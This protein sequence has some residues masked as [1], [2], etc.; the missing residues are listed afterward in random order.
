MP[1]FGSGKVVRGLGGSAGFGEMEMQRGDDL[2]LRLDLSS[3]FPDGFNY[4]GTRYGVWGLFVNTNGTLSFGTP[5]ASY[6]DVGNRSV[7]RNL[8]APL[9]S[10]V[11]TRID[12][13]GTESGSI[14]IDLDAVRDVV[15][16]TWA[17]V[18][19]YRRNADQTNLFQ[20]QLFDRG[21]GDFDLAMRYERIE[22]TQG[23]GTYDDGGRA[24]LAARNFTKPQW[25]S[26]F[27]SSAALMDLP[28]TVGNTGVRGL[29]VYEMRDGKV[30]DLGTVDGI[31]RTGTGQDDVLEGTEFDDKLTA[32]GGD[33]VLF[34]EDGSD[35]L[36]GGDGSDTL[37]G[38]GGDDFIFAGDTS[39]DLHDVV[40]GG[41][42]NDLVEAGYGNDLVYGGNGDDDLRGSYGIDTLMGQDGNDTLTGGALSDYLY[43]GAGDDFIN[44]GVGYDRLRGNAGA[45]R[46]YHGGA[47]EHRCDWIRD[48][49]QAE[50][51]I[52]VFGLKNRSPLL[53]RVN[54]GETPGAGEDG[55]PEAFVV[56]R[57]T[58]QILWAL[59]DGGTQSSVT[60]F[61]TGQEYELFL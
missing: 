57:P 7:A 36:Y 28:D 51:D 11:D 13:E 34:G 26:P 21:G 1:V 59:I 12:G 27:G 38:G 14:W 23:T 22:W 6:P 25:L 33:D 52:L 30:T 42:G 49:S 60:L 9:W 48:Y 15:T 5:F 17:D 58:G 32:L 37:V 16:I 47:T 39:A 18:G 41:D 31:E 43:G 4:F 19:A 44:G 61:M 40:F 3:V 10:D 35:Y 2:A 24:L 29:W 53:F 45:D 20:V 8:I 54:V 56:Y 55:V 46:F 50:G